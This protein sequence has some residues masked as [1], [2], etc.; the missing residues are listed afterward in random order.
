MIESLWLQSGPCIRVAIYAFSDAGEVDTAHYHRTIVKAL[1]R[2]DATEARE[3]LV[4]D[5]SRPF[6]FLRNKLEADSKKGTSA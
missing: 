5:I 3:A 2:Q 1:A 4:A 6:V